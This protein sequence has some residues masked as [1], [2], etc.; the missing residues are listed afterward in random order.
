MGCGSSSMTPAV[1]ETVMPSKSIMESARRKKNQFHKHSHLLNI[2]DETVDSM[3]DFRSYAVQRQQ[4][5][6]DFKAFLHDDTDNPNESEVSLIYIHVY[7]YTIL[8]MCMYV[9]MYV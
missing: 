2:I 8:H 1:E 5:W 9:C 4:P 6:N 7:I 3:K